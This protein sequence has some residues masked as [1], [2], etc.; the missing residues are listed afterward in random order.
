MLICALMTL[1]NVARYKSRGNSAYYLGGA[2]L[3]LGATVYAYTENA[4][5]WVL[6]VGGLVVFLLLAADM[7]YRVGRQ[8]K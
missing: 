8:Q 2:F 4:P 1:I 7:V 5:R 3:L 6:G